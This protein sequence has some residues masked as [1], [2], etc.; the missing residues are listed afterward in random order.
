[1]RWHTGL[2]RRLIIA[3][4][5]V[6]L[7]LSC[8]IK[9]ST[10]NGSVAESSLPSATETPPVYDLVIMNGRV[11]DP[12]HETNA[13]MNLGIRDGV[14]AY[15]GSEAIQGKR[16]VNAQGHWVTPGFIDL[17]S[18]AMT[19]FGQYYQ[20]RDGVTTALELE[21]GVYPVAALQQHFPEGSALHYG[22]SVSHLAAR[23]RVLG[24][25]VQPHFTDPPAPL[26]ADAPLEPKAGFVRVADAEQIAL[27]RAD[28]ERGIQAGAL[29]IGLL[30]DYV[31]SAVSTEELEALFS[32]SGDYNVP[33]FVHIRRGLPGDLAGLEE[34][35]TLA[36]TYNTPLHICH[37]QASTMQ[38]VTRALELISTAKSSGLQV[39][40]EAYP[41]HAGST[42]IGAAVFGRDWEAIF[43]ISYADIQWAA[44][45]ERLTKERFDTLRKQQPMGVVIHHYGESAWTEAAITAPDVI[46]A[47]D[48]MPLTS[49]TTFVHPRGLGTFTRVLSRYTAALD[50]EGSLA[51]S[52]AIA[53]MTTLPAEVL[54][55]AFPVFNQ[56]GHLGIGADADIAILDP[57]H[58]NDNS[59]YLS[60]LQAASGVRYLLVC[61]QPLIENTVW[62]ENSAAGRVLS[63]PS[64]D[65]SCQSN[66]TP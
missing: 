66:T 61:G 65:L 56:K 47:S 22:A 40:T 39:S 44:T 35:L 36:K 26:V 6:G 58:L 64:A 57:Q 20:A 62:Q 19:P 25:T 7:G 4:L 13:L 34:V 15:R 50:A 52:S 21:A 63:S 46:I 2:L 28:V 3:T 31:A 33:I 23:Q 45:G 10:I 59:T 24:N 29:G 51:L 42:S 5:P 38:G 54:R 41:Y 9:A 14:I 17:H 1:V 49:D 12:Q 37:L 53:K 48:A 55:P 32:V 27:I 43:D 16:T 30:L 60:P 8:L 11:I 18:H